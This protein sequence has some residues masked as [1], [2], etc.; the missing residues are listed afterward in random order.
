MKGIPIADDARRQIVE[1]YRTESAK[2]VA[3]RYGVS[4]PTVLTFVRA[5]GEPIRPPFKTMRR[6]NG[7]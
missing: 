7:R 5:A 2:A 3:R 1:A 4:V 6:H